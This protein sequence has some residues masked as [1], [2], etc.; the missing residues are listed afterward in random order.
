VIAANK[1]DLIVEADY[2]KDD[3][4]AAV[5]EQ[6]EGRF[7]ILRNTPIIAMSSLT[8][9][10]VD[11]LMPAVFDARDRWAQTIPTGQLNRWLA[12]VLDGR[13]PPMMSGKPVRIKYIMQAKGRPPTFL[14]FCNTDTLPDSYVRYLVR[15]FQ[16]TFRMYGMEIRLAVKKSAR[17]NPFDPANKRKRGGSGLGGHAARKSRLLQERRETYVGCSS[18]KEG[19][20]KARKKTSMKRR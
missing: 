15:H 6:L 19:R 12:E 1:M 5:R 11:D 16:D 3:F 18:K 4:A 14:L 7:P 9:E 2:T 17:D 8:G 20:S 13:S 10:A